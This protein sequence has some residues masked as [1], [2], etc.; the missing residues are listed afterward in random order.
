LAPKVDEELWLLMN[1]LLSIWQKRWGPM[2]SHHKESFKE[3]EFAKKIFQGVMSDKW[4]WNDVQSCV[5]A[6]REVKNIYN[7][8]LKKSLDLRKASTLQPKNSKMRKK[9]RH[10]P[11]REPVELMPPGTLQGPSR[12]RRY[13]G[14]YDGNRP[15]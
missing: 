9:K 6:N 13:S 15:D 4:S 3:N 1:R 8:L 11:K 5:Y 12:E 2:H 7:C 14:N 10:Q